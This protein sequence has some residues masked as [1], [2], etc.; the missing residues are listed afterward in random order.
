MTIEPS[1]KTG[2]RSCLHTVQRDLDDLRPAQRNVRLAQEVVRSSV[3]PFVRTPPVPVPA[4][5]PVP[6]PVP[7]PFQLGGPA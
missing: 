2:G 6:A 7:A 4:P 3:R 5:A 1:G